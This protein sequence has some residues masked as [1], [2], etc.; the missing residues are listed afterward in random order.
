M[1]KL[2]K[3]IEYAMLALMELDSLPPEETMTVKTIVSNTNLPKALA[4]KILQELNRHEIVSSIQGINGG[5]RL[6]KSFSKIRLKD[7]IEAVDGP[8]G[9]VDCLYDDGN[10]ENSIHCELQTPLARIQ[11]GLNKY[12]M[13]ITMDDIKEM[14]GNSGQLVGIGR[15]IKKTHK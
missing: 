6:N 5:Y 9:L 1:L 14:N 3:K 7:I 11:D 12:L 4:G 8:I 13:N 2:N 15:Q 10:C